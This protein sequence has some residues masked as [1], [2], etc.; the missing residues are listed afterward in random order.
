MSD[1]QISEEMLFAEE[2]HRTVQY[3]RNYLPQ[4][5]KEKFSEDDIYYFLDAFVEYCEQKGIM[6]NED[7]ETDIDIDEAAQFMCDLAKKENQGVF[8]PEDVR[9]VVDGQLE[10]WEQ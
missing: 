7:E 3:I 4:E 9:W 1:I 6:D 8:E 5:V 2:E 10:F